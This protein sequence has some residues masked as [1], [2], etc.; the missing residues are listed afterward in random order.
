MLS[1]STM[2]LSDYGI[3]FS[4]TIK[5]DVRRQL[6]AFA[7]IAQFNRNGCCRFPSNFTSPDVNRAR[8]TN[9]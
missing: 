4:K 9:I 3:H 6:S 2:A 8:L 7:V 1:P 5:R